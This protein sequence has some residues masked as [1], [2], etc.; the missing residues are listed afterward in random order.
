MPIVPRAGPMTC[1]RV[2][3]L[4][5]PPDASGAG[6]ASEGQRNHGSIPALDLGHVEHVGDHV[7]R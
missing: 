4:L 3:Y 6:V 2:M 5:G 1:L 7:N